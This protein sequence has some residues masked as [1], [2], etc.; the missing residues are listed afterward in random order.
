MWVI[1]CSDVWAKKLGLATIS[2]SRWISFGMKA[3]GAKK[4]EKKCEREREREIGKKKSTKERGVLVIA[5]SRL[6]KAQEGVQG[7]WDTSADI[8]IGRTNS[9]LRT[10]KIIVG[11]RYAAH[12]TLADTVCT[13]LK[14]FF[15]RRHNSLQPLPC[16]I[17]QHYVHVARRRCTPQ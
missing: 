16:R 6:Q 10:K 17:T 9:E 1:F 11:V 3:E 14:L 4:L 2:V 15:E 8:T 7:N 5:V 12:H 13:T